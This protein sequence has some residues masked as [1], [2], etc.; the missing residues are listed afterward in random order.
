MRALKLIPLVVL[1]APMMVVAPT[2]V[3]D[4]DR[5]D[6]GGI[7]LAVGC[8]HGDLV[9]DVR[10]EV[11]NDGDSGVTRYWAYDSYRKR[12]RVWQVDPTSFCAVVQYEGKFVSTAGPSP[13]G[14]DPN[15]IAEGIRG[16]MTGGYRVT[17]TGALNPSPAYR[18]RGNLGKFDY[19]WAGD[20]SS[21][22]PNPFRWADVYFSSGYTYEYAW[23]GWVYNAGRHGIWFNTAGNA[24]DVTD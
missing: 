19:G 22:A 7:E 3:A 11:V 2:A 21:P 15:G 8:P 5:D 6:D 4:D 17:I 10:H 20:G 9:I 13:M 14:T 16:S 18:S 1:L 12:I 24:G 23:W